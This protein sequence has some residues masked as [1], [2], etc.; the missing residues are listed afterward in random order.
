MRGTKACVIWC[1]PLEVLKLLLQPS[2]HFKNCI[3][4]HTAFW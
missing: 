1:Y 3:E 2:S 4:R